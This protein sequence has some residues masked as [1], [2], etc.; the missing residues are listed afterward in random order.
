V[1][2]HIS[3]TGRSGEIDAYMQSRLR[4]ANIPG[5]G[6]GVVRD[7][8]DVCLKDYGTA[9]AYGRVDLDTVRTA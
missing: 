6:L 8:Q 1:L 5:L 9:G 3:H 2:R 4:I 7:N